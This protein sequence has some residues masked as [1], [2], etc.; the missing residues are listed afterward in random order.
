MNLQVLG[1]GLTYVRWEDT[2][3]S[4]RGKARVTVMDIQSDVLK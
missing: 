2:A 1:A 4:E 3:Q